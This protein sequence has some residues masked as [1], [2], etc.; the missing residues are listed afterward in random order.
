MAIPWDSSIFM[1][2]SSTRLL[3]GDWVIP[4]AADEAVDANRNGSRPQG[5]C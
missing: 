3:W 2:P 1:V 5:S 4:V